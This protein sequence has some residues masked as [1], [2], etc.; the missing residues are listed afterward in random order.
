MFHWTSFVWHAAV[1]QK[2]ELFCKYLL[3]AV[4]WTINNFS[5]LKPWMLCRTL[6]AFRKEMH[7]NTHTKTPVTDLHFKYLYNHFPLNSGSL[8][9]LA[10]LISIFV[11]QWNA[12]V[13]FWKSRCYTWNTENISLKSKLGLLPNEVYC[14]L[15]IYII[16]N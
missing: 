7:T 12:Q 1:W 3:S 6:D 8:V 10:Y 14:H 4:P 13:P 9:R 15:W 5:S 2:T 16:C 11:F